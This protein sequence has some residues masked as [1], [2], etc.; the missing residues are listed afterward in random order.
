MSSLILSY[1]FMW[2]ITVKEYIDYYQRNK[3]LDKMYIE[4]YGN[5]DNKCY[6]K[7]C[8]ELVVEL[9]E[10]AN[11]SKCFKYWSM[12]KPDKDALLEEYADCL[13]MLLC[14]FNYYDIDNLELL[15]IELSFDI[16]FVFNEIIRMC[17]LLMNK[18]NV[19]DNLLKEI[20]TYLLH[21]AKLLDI[22][23]RD[24]LDACYKK[25]GKNIERLNSDY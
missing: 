2:V 21:I 19:N 15:D 10:L 25:I 9:S 1:F 20:F 24:I 23:D 11:E 22:T 7:N 17:T 18:D 13:S 5:I 16:I 4:R 3:Q 14:I 6:E 12:K 8:L